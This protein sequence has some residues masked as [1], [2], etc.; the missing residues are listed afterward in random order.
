[1][2]RQ[3]RTRGPCH[4]TRPCQISRKYKGEKH[5]WQRRTRTIV[6]KDTPM[7]GQNSPHI[8][9]F[10]FS[11]F[12][13]F[14][15]IFFIIGGPTSIFSRFFFLPFIYP[16]S[17]FLLPLSLQK[18]QNS[19]V[20]TSKSFHLS[21]LNHVK[22]QIVFMKV[23]PIFF[24]Q[25]SSVT[26]S[27]NSLFQILIL[28]GPNMAPKRISRGKQPTREPSRSRARSNLVPAPNINAHGIMFQKPTQEV[29]Y[30][31][32]IWRKLMPT[33]YMIS[34]TLSALGMSAGIN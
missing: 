25:L 15:V 21:P 19:I 24:L 32:H 5:L 26:F 1:M 13:Y 17:T 8:V 30:F 16:F 2:T 31:Y 27:T 12:I 23:A 20:T 34:K 33:R 4:L 3:R 9:F 18:F 10:V 14:F 11:Y 22:F 7:S 28:L 29:R 6:S